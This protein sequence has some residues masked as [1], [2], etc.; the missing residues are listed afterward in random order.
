MY[1]K[2]LNKTTKINED[3]F[4]YATKKRGGKQSYSNTTC[5]SY[6][7]MNSPPNGELRKG[8]EPVIQEGFYSIFITIF[9]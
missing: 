6:F 4:A 1:S 9:Q 3:D 2:A 8:R 7:A 5:T